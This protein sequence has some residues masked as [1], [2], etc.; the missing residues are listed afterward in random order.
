MAARYKGVIKQLVFLLTGQVTGYTRTCRPPH[1]LFLWS[2]EQPENRRW[3]I[4]VLA[5]APSSR[6]FT[7]PRGRN[8]IPTNMMAADLVTSAVPVDKGRAQ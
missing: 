8:F 2:V 5:K 7:S 6:K 1:S 3:A 4:S